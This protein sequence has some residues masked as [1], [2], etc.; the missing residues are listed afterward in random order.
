M[1]ESDKELADRLDAWER[2]EARGY[3]RE[4]C[5]NCGGIGQSHPDIVCN[6]CEGKGYYWQAPITK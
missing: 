4:A 6:R 3:K 5:E 1:A 2:L